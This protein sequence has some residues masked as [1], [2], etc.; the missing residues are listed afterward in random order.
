MAWW[1]FRRREAK[2][3]DASALAWAYGTASAAG[4]SVTVERALQVS[5]V[6][7]CAR[8][9]SE[10]IAQ[11]PC[12]LYREHDDGGKGPATDHP[13]YWL[14]YRRP[15][16]WMTSFEFRELL[17]FHAVLTGAGYAYINR[18]RGEVRELLPILP[19]NIRPR[20]DDGY[21]LTFEVADGKGLIGTFRRDQIL[22]LRGPSWDSYRALDIVQSA[23]EAIGLAIATEAN[24]AKL[25][26]NGSRPGGILSTDQPLQDTQIARI[27]QAWQAAYSGENQFKTAVLDNGF[28]WLP[29]AMTGV[30][31]Q[32]LES[33]RFQIEEICRAMR[34]FPQMV[35]SSDK[36]STYA[37]AEQFFLAHVIHSLGPWVERWEQVLSRDLLTPAE[38]KSG[39]FPKLTVAGLLRGD[40]KARAEFYRT[41]SALAAMNPNEIRS[42]EDMNPYDGGDAYSRQVN[43]A[44]VGADGQSILPEQ[45]EASPPPREEDAANAAV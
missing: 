22:Y 24:Q 3:T 33:R 6:L 35:M 31:A 27:K 18:V 14:L 16:E 2:A 28:K 11:L 29:M 9:I 23:R 39:L 45:P 42:L 38:A 44:P 1:P 21:G 13:L 34:V 15:N 37:S 25:F 43:I 30:D 40:I 8:V 10:G 32:Q 19:G 5:T 17:S 12:K 20:Q 26:G 41:M 36:T 4:V 7:A